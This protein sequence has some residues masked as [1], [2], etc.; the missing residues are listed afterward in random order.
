MPS[1]ETLLILAAV[2]TICDFALI[3]IDRFRGHGQK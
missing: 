1:L 2:C 3:L